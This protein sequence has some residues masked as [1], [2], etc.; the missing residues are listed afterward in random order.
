MYFAKACSSIKQSS[1]K[2][3]GFQLYKEHTNGTV[4]KTKPEFRIVNHMPPCYQLHIYHSY[5]VPTM[6][7][8]SACYIKQHI[9]LQHK[10]IGYFVGYLVPTILD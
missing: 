8:K 3:L 9:L 4:F 5:L 2:G 6:Q 1:L 7:T 10:A